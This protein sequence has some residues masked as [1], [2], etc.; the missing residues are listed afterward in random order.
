MLLVVYSISRDFSDA[1][2]RN[3]GTEWRQPRC[4]YV[5][6]DC[7]LFLVCACVVTSVILPWKLVGM[8]M[9][10]C[11]KLCAHLW[12]QRLLAG[13]HRPLNPLFVVCVWEVMRV[14]CRSAVNPAHLLICSLA[15]QSNSPAKAVSHKNQP[16]SQHI[17]AAGISNSA[18]NRGN[19][20]Q[21]PHLTHKL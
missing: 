18:G 1:R 7:A 5:G 20:S 2:G 4:V 6:F 14:V 16:L 9:S 10:V 19:H 11:V 13:S 17:T 3:E 21:S 15:W 12:H 8:E